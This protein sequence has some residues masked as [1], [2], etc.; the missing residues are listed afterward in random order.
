MEKITKKKEGPQIALEEDYDSMDVNFFS[1]NDDANLGVDVNMSMNGANKDKH[2]KLLGLEENQE[3]QEG[4]DSTSEENDLFAEEDDDFDRETSFYKKLDNLTSC[5]LKDVCAKMQLKNKKQEK[6]N[7]R[8]AEE[9]LKRKSA[10]AVNQ[11]NKL[12]KDRL[13]LLTKAKWR[14]AAREASKDAYAFSPI[15]RGMTTTRSRRVQS[16]ES[17]NEVQNRINLEDDEVTGNVPDDVIRELKDTREAEARAKTKARELRKE[18]EMVRREDFTRLI[19][20]ATKPYWMWALE[21]EENLQEVGLTP[22]YS[23][24]V[25]EQVMPMLKACLL[26]TSPSPRDKRQSRMPSSA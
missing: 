1:V 13:K 10:D 9:L 24:N 4:N 11:E 17:D 3:E 22:P 8:S 16:L 12:L 20:R 14:T 6:I 21:I 15:L 25:S 18:I 26:Y 23:K 7:A 5:Q 19:P 2:K